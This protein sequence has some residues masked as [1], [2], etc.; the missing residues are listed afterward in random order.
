MDSRIEAVAGLQH[1][2]ISRSQ[3]NAVV[4]AA[5]AKALV[6]SG[7]L[8]GIHRGVYRLPSAPSTPW[9][10]GAA[11]VLAAR[12]PS[13]TTVLTAA[14]DGGSPRA[15]FTVVSQGLAAVLWELAPAPRGGIAD[16]TGQR[17]CRRPGIRMHRVALAPDEVGSACGVPA[18]SPARTVLDVAG[19]ASARR[20]EQALAAAL[21][22]GPS[23]PGDLAALLA[24]HRNHPGS[25]VLRRLLELSAAG[26][27]P[28]FLRSEAEEAFLRLLRR[29][30][31]S[32]PAA[33]ETI[34]GFEVD[35][36]WQQLGLVVEIDGRAFHD[37]PDAFASDRRRDRALAAAG[38]QVLRFT[39]E[40]VKYEGEATVAAVAATAAQRHTLRHYLPDPLPGGGRPLRPRR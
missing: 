32:L 6:R 19:S 33:N 23:I 28:I 3:V 17:V 1:G 39:W 24:R 16:V 27:S 35:F 5:T 38:Y 8:V 37:R 9:R 12:P 7:R 2:A 20:A 40:Q 21:R 36:V 25:P 30:K 15:G 26:V 18:T 11:A 10:T 14:L 22:L 34:L 13:D 4:G 29:A 31:L